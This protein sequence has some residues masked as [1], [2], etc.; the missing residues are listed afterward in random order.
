MNPPARNDPNLS[1]SAMML[2]APRLSR[3][4][5]QGSAQ[6]TWRRC[7]NPILVGFMPKTAEDGTSEHGCKANG[8]ADPR[9]CSSQAGGVTWSKGPRRRASRMVQGEGFEPDRG[10]ARRDPVCL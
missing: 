7:E 4:P 6:K 1:R 9:S 10:V 2:T 5:S 3:Y 8:S